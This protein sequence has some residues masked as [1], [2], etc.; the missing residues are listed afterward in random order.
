MRVQVLDWDK[1]SQAQ[2]ERLGAQDAAAGVH[3]ILVLCDRE[4]DL[5]IVSSLPTAATAL[6][7]S[8]ALAGVHQGAQ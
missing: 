7:L 8:D 2:V 4:G 1:A 3:A 5:R 6:V